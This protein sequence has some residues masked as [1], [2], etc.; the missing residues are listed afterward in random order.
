MLTGLG[1][2]TAAQG[3]QLA[4]LRIDIDQQLQQIDPQLFGSNV[5]WNAQYDFLQP[6]STRYYPKFLHQVRSVGYSVQRFPGGTLASFYHWNG[7]SGR[8][9]TAGRTR[10]SAA[11]RKRRGSARTSSGDC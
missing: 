3:S 7:R 10:S 8:S 4:G 1:L 6:E 5:A 2:P 9:R 11:V